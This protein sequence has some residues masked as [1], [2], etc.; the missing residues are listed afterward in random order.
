MFK[1]VQL[2]VESCLKAADAKG[3]RSLAFPA[4]GTGQSHYPANEV[5]KLMVKQI[6]EYVDSNQ[7]TRLQ[8]I[9]IVIYQKDSTTAQV[10]KDKTN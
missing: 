6:L 7:N 4:I 5:A 2:I 3:Y 9:G 8:E 1:N 10:Q